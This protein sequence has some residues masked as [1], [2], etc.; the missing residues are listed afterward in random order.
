MD[1]IIGVISFTYDLLTSNYL[2]FGSFSFS[3]FDVLISFAIIALLGFF[4][5]KLFQSR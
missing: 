1:N 5:G 2:S 3:L 4:F